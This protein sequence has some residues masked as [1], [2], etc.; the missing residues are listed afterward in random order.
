MRY[1]NPVKSNCFLILVFVLLGL[2]A[3]GQGNTD[4]TAERSTLF[5]L[6]IVY[7]TP[8]TRWAFGGAGFLS[9]RFKNEPTDTRP[10]QIQLGGAYTLNDQILAYL[11]Y[12][13]WWNKE[14]NTVFGELGWYRYNYYYFGIG[15]QKPEDFRELYGVNYPRLRLSWLHKVAANFLI[16]PRFTV[17]DFKITE[18]DPDGELVNGN[19][20]GAEGGLN[21]GAEFLCAMIPATTYLKATPGGSVHL[22]STVMAGF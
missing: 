8:E 3:K 11:S 18:L 16:G 1:F 7:Y 5:G 9:W 6:P 2:S 10:S 15:N 22:L 20:A 19:V 21:S 4:T 14:Q 12:E 13:L 17:D